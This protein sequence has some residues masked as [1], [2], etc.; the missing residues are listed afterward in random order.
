ID[1][2]LADASTGVV[3]RKLVST[4]ADPHFDSLQFLES[5]GAWDPAGRAFALATV[6]RGHPVLTLLDMPG[7]ALRRER[8]FEELDQIY[9]AA[10][11]PGGGGIAFSAMRGGRTALYV[12]DLQEDRL[13]RL[14]ADAYADLQPA[15]S[16]DGGT[17]AFVTDRFSSSLDALTFGAYRLAL[18]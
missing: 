8:T 5:A 12:Y 11:A 14:T 9:S 2:F 4:A 6:Q 13:P 18:F 3:V 15:W 16:P 10:G 1:V 17:I 7:G